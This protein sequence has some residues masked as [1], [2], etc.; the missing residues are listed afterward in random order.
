[1]IFIDLYT[2]FKRLLDL[3]DKYIHLEKETASYYVEEIGD[4]LYIFF[5]WSNGKTDWLNNLN[6][7]AKPYRDM[8]NTWFCHRGFLKVWKV[9]EPHLA[10][11]I[12]NPQIKTIIIAGYSHGG[13]IA[14]LCHEY[15]KFNRPEVSVVGVGYGAP[16]VVWGYVNNT[17]KQRF[18]DFIVVRNGCDLVTHLPPKLLGFRDLGQIY[19]IGKPWGLIKD[20][21]PERY[22]QALFRKFLFCYSRGQR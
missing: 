12:L 9:L 13:A 10:P 2:L 17:V 7:P 16:R 3:K 4:T 20:H 11:H 5:E 15:V 18:K 8:K 6:F 21:Y 14:Q 1:M 22:E 19:K